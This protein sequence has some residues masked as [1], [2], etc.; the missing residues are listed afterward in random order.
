MTGMLGGEI[1]ALWIL[2]AP[3]S[4]H[5]KS[6]KLRA[7]AVTSAQR[8]AA[9]PDVPTVAESSLPDFKLVDWIGL[10]APA[11]TPQPIID[12]L[13]SAFRAAIV[14]PSLKD[15][16][17]VQGF[18][19]SPQSSKDLAKQIGINVKL[20]A[21]TVR[22]AT[23][24]EVKGLRSEARQLKEALAEVTLENRLLKKSVVAD[25]DLDT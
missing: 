6:G 22:E 17:L 2:I 1:D 7:L 3:V 21:D 16:L 11:G 25:G 24:D 13:Q 18:V 4:A 20:W 19:P 15:K 9:L 5:V 8:N 23:S 12:K 14:D 10:M